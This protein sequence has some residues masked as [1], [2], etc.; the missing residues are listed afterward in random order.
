MVEQKRGNS[1]IYKKRHY[2]C[3]SCG[4]DIPKQILFANS[5]PQVEVKI[6]KGKSPQPR[7]QQRQKPAPKTEKIWTAAKSLREGFTMQELVAACPNINERTVRQMF[8]IF[9]SEGLLEDIGQ[10]KP[11]NI[12]CCPQCK[13]EIKR[14]SL[15]SKVDSPLR[16]QKATEHLRAYYEKHEKATPALDKVLIAIENYSTKPEFT[17][18]ELHSVVPEVKYH[19]LRQILY[20]LAKEERAVSL[21]NPKSKPSVFIKISNN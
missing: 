14:M 11:S 12:I 6:C 4:Y 9:R 7:G 19:T 3:P 1:P 15:V 20:K 2:N 5:R 8:Y 16:N 17:A 18:L 13:Q 10:R 21:A